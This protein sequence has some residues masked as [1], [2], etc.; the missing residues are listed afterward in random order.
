MRDWSD[1][2]S[3]EYYTY[4]QNVIDHYRRISG[5]EDYE[6]F[7]E[8]LEIMPSG[9]FEEENGEGFEVCEETSSV[10]KTS[11]TFPGFY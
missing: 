6:D 11:S 10:H 5:Y 1:G 9:D 2:Y 3:Y 8:E 4:T 7:E